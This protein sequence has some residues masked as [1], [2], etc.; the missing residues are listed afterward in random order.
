MIQRAPAFVLAAALLVALSLASTAWAQ[1]LRWDMPNEYPETSIHGEGDRFFARDLAGRSTGRIDITHHFDASLG[2]RSK[3]LLDAI[4][5]GKVALGDMYV[6]ALGGVHPI[7]LLP[8]L[9][10]LAVT[11]AEARRLVDVARPEYER[12]L[13]QH[14]QK[15]L[16][17]SPW[18]PAGLWAKKPVVSVEDLKGLRVRTADANATLAMRA[19]GAQ[20]QQISFADTLPLLKTGAID[21]VLSSGDGGAGDRLMETLTHFTAI[22]FSMTMSMVTMNLDTWKAL[23]PD[24]QEAVLAAA[25]ATSE[26]QWAEIVNRVSTNY[27]RMR[28]KGIAIVTDLSPEYQAALRAAGQV[29]VDNWLA[30]MGPTGKDVLDRYRQ[31]R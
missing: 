30:A 20:P 23:P 19:A 31:R 24:L 26:R 29:A 28:G 5:Q 15:L 16:Y 3:D 12:V 8:S 1:T 27:E 21:A 14:N 22:G 6:G 11:P 10:F 9:P 25:A 13:A 7:F 2:Y 18:P 4:G 17:P